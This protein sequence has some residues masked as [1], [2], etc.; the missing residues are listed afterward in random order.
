MNVLTSL[1]GNATTAD[2]AS[3][4]PLASPT[5]TGT[6]LGI[7]KAMVDLANV[8]ITTDA[9]KPVSAATTTQFSLRTDKTT[10]D[11]SA[12]A[13][14]AGLTS[15]AYH[16]LNAGTDAL[17]VRT[18]SGAIAA[19]FL[20]SA[21]GASYDGK[22]IFYKDFQVLGNQTVGGNSSITCNLINIGNNL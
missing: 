12:V 17:V 4:A 15:D 20:G 2:L 19:N 16:C 21:G 1:N 14:S 6:V 22:V 11:N 8:D 10:T 7:T 3:N 13:W 9:L 18:G 5:S